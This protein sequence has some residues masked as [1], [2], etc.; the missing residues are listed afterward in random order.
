[1]IAATKT[2]SYPTHSVSGKAIEAPSIKSGLF[3]LPKELNK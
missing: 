1:M 3:Y 2:K